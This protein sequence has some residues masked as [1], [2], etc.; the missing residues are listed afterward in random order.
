MMVEIF[1]V[2]L[3]F[4]PEEDVFKQEY[5]AQNYH[6]EVVSEVPGEKCYYTTIELPLSADFNSWSDM[7][8]A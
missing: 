6:V 3:C 4:I 2:L 8:A 5:L 7:L 1:T